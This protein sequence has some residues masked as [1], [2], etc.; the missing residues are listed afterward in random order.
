MKKKC[1]PQFHNSISLGAVITCKGDW[2][3]GIGIGNHTIKPQDCD[4]M[5]VAKALTLVE[6]IHSDLKKK[7]VAFLN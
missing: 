6:A 7:I 1:D 4:L 5:T 3:Y 2:T